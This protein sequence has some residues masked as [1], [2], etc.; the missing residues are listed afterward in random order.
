MPRRKGIINHFFPEELVF[1]EIKC[2]D[3]ATPSRLFAE[4]GLR[5]NKNVILVSK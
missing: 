2:R 3:V 1:R 4:M 5:N